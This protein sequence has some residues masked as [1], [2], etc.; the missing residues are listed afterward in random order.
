LQVAGCR[1]SRPLDSIVDPAGVVRDGCWLDW[2][3]SGPPLHFAHANGF[4]PAIYRRLFEVFRTR[5]RVVSME[6]RPLWPGTE[7]AVLDDWSLLADDLRDELG[8]R[9]IRGCVGVGHSLGAVCSLLAAAGDPGLFSAVVAIDP[10]VLT[11]WHSRL[12]GV[13][14][15]VGVGDALPIV[16]GAR[17]RRHHWPD[18]DSVRAGYRSKKMFR[19][20]EPEVFDDYLRYGIVAGRDG[21]VLR[22]PKAWE[23]QVFRVSPHD[24]WPLLRRMPVPTIFVE[25]EHSD[26][27]LP[28]AADRVRREVPGTRVLV[29]PESSH[30]VPMERPGEMG[31]AIM[32]ALDEITP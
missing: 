14:K 4:P 11:G 18:R 22:Y 27:F 20:W 31:R 8:R 29:N 2:G 5:Y 23:A 12:W 32:A 10:I 9:G 6:A 3:G 30:F 21:V 1:S 19:W 28:P 25:G 24:L 26:T 13:M 16:R 17:R 15:A 7:P